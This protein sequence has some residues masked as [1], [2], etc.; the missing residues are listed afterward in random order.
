[1]LTLPVIVAWAPRAMLPILSAP[2]APAHEPS[3]YQSGTILPAL[4]L[5]TV[6][7][8]GAP[9]NWWPTVLA[10][11]Y[12]AGVVLLLSNVARGVWKSRTL[13]QQA[14]LI[15]GR[16]THAACVAPVTVGLGRPV[17]IL[18]PDW[19][20]WDEVDLQAVLAHEEEH[21]R[22]RDPLVAMLTLTNRAVFWFHPLA[23]WLRRRIA[24][25]SEQ[26]CDAEVI[27][28]G[29]DADRYASTLLRFARAVSS[30]G[31]RLAAPAL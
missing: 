22:R 24:T 26:A 25:L 28:A 16:L 15:S 17:V 29:H 14:T 4:T 18:P 2:S 12:A 9:D 7:V 3:K 31:G 5:D 13:S 27:G 6:P 10:G 21:A 20:A 19:M 23:W 30:S 1:M 11:L 8:G